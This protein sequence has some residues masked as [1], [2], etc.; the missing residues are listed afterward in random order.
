MNDDDLKKLTDAARK[1]GKDAARNDKVAK[2]D[3]AWVKEISVQVVDFI[4]KSSSIRTI[5][6][7][8]FPE[9]QIRTWNRISRKT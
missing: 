5:P 4:E 1:H 2:D 9:W 6:R 8:S 7:N 3:L